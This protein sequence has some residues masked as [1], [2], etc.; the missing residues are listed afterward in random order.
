[1]SGFVTHITRGTRMLRSS[2][3]ACSNVASSVRC[4]LR[5]TPA[6]S[7]NAR[8]PSG[9]TP[10][11]RMPQIVGMRGSSHPLTMPVVHE[12][13]QLSLAQHRVVELEPREL[14]L[15]RRTL[16]AALAHEPLVDVVVVLELERAERVRDALDRVGQRMSKV[17]QRIQTPRV[18]LPVVMRVP[19]A[20]QQRIAH[21]HVRMRH[22]DLA[23]AARAR[24]RGTRR[25]SCAAADRDS[26]R[27]CDR[28]T[29]CSFPAS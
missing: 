7:A 9:V 1:M 2:R 24:R 20:Q 15:L 3:T 13:Q 5:D 28:D 12:T 16:E 23:R 29:G 18:A 17:V 22:V 10:R 27:P 4:G 26:R 21:D 14:R 19:N 6:V 8:S 25:P 11:R